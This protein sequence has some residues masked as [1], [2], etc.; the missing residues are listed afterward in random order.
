MPDND[1][2]QWSPATRVLKYSPD[3]V[4]WARRW[5]QGGRLTGSKLTAMFRVPEEGCAE[6]EGNSMTVAGQLNLAYLLTGNP[7]GLPL[8]PTTGGAAHVL[9]GVGSDSTPNP[10][11]APLAA[12]TL[13]PVTGESPHGTYYQEMDPGYPVVQSPNLLS[14]QALFTEDDANFAWEEWCLAVCGKTSCGGGYSLQ[15]A[16]P[17][18]V[19]VNRRAVSHGVKPPG[20]GWLFQCT[21]RLL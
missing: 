6:S 7:E 20:R 10:T 9:L 19:M 1:F 16:A 14:A 2:V 15:Q 4:S 12:A 18:S 11:T 8:L 5:L 13:S 21:V 17:G 3:Q